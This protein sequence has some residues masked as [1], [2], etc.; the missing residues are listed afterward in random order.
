MV[1]KDVKG[2]LAET[3]DDGVQDDVSLA[4]DGNA[5]LESAI[6]YTATSSFYLNSRRSILAT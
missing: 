5:E 3:K 1:A 6:A 4:V 2:G